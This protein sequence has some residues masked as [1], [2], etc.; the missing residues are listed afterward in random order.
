MCQYVPWKVGGSK[1]MR[2]ETISL[3]SVRLWQLI[4]GKVTRD[5]AE[6]DGHTG[7]AIRIVEHQFI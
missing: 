5:N 6:S 3:E 2:R 1:E 7:V 4:K